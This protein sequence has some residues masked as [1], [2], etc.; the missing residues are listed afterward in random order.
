MAAL[1]STS[2]QPAQ[3]SH[4]IYTPGH[5]PACSS[6][7]P[8]AIM[9]KGKHEPFCA[10][11]KLGRVQRGEDVFHTIHKESEID[12]RAKFVIV[13]DISEPPNCDGYDRVV[14]LR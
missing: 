7:I 2:G 9:F 11:Q 1:N 8:G 14:F 12:L 4:L 5:S 6:W 3:L 13:T 10:P